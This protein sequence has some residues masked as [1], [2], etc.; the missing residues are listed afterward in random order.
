MDGD[1]NIVRP[2]PTVTP[3]VAAPALVVRQGDDITRNEE[4]QPG[5][6]I[7]YSVTIE[8]RGDLGA[9]NLF[10][11]V[12]FRDSEISE[13]ELGLVDGGNP[14]SDT[15]AALLGNFSVLDGQK[16]RPVQ[17]G[18]ERISFCG[19]TERFVDGRRKSD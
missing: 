8:N 1:G 13:L 11:R 14:L 4:K 7:Q 12:P 2:A 5:D 6:I 3:I 16:R 9:L 15:A 17:R 18:V 19:L 10:Y